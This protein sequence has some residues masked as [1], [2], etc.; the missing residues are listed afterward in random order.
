MAS[1]KL[2]LWIHDERFSPLDLIVQPENLSGYAVGDILEIRPS[3][4]VNDAVPT[5]KRLVMKVTGFDADICSKQTQLQI[6]INQHIAAI[7]ELQPRKDVVVS[8]IDPALIAADCI[9]L[10]FKDQYIGRGDMFRLKNSLTESCIYVGKKVLF[11]GCIRAQVKEIYA[12]GSQVFSAYVT[13][14]TKVIFRSE[15]AKYFIFLQ[16]S[17]DMF[18]MDSSGN[19]LLDRAIHGFFPELFERW[20]SLNSNHVVSIILSAR[21]FYDMK[22]LEQCE[23]LRG[24]DYYQQSGKHH[25]DY[26][27]VVS[28]WETRSDWTTILS[29]L[30]GEV[31]KF[32]DRIMMQKVKRMDVVMG[33]L[34]SSHESNV[35][36]AVN[37]ALN[38][39]DKHY[40]D[41]DL[42]RTGLSITM[43]TGGSGS[44]TVDKNLLRLT[45]ERMIEDGI[46]LDWVCLNKPPLF[47][48]PLFRFEGFTQ[49]MNAT[50]D[51]LYDDDVKDGP[52]EV[53]CN[54]PH[55]VDMSFYFDY[56][57]FRF[58]H[59]SRLAPRVQFGGARSKRFKAIIPPLT[60]NVSG[61]DI[62]DN[63]SNPANQAKHVGLISQQFNL[64]NI[65]Q[66]HDGFADNMSPTGGRIAA[67]PD[68]STTSKITLPA[69]SNSSH[70]I[71]IL[72]VQKK[73]ERHELPGTSFS[74]SFGSMQAS[75]M[76]QIAKEDR[77]NNPTTFPSN[78]AYNVVRISNHLRRWHHVFPRLSHKKFDFVKWNSLCTPACLPLTTDYFPTL[79]E[80]QD[81]YQEYTY[82]ISLNYEDSSASSSEN[83]FME[84]IAQRLIQGF[85]LVVDNAHVLEHVYLSMGQQIHKLVY[86]RNAQNVD[87]KRYVKR[88]QYATDEITY[89]CEISTKDSYE[90]S[91][92]YVAFLYPS[93]GSYN[94]NYLDHV[95]SGYQEELT[96]SLRFWRTRFILIPMETV[97]SN[98]FLN[99]SNESL[100]EEEIRLAGF[101]KFIEVF[102]RGGK[103]VPVV[104]TTLNTSTYVM[105]ELNVWQSPADVPVESVKSDLV[106][107]LSKDSKLAAITN[108]LQQGIT[109]K[110]RRWHLKYY[111]NAFVGSEC[112][113]WLVR[114]F[115]DIKTRE[116]AVDFGRTLL[117]KGIF[118]HVNSKHNFLDGHYFYRVSTK[119]PSSQAQISSPLRWFKK[120]QQQQITNQSSNAKKVELSRKILIDLDPQKKSYRIE[121]AVLHFD[122]VHNPNNCFHFHLHWLMCTSRLLDDMLQSWSRFAEKCGLK[123]VEAPV[124]SQD[125]PF[126]APIEIYPCVLPPKVNADWIPGSFK[127]PEL[128]FEIALLKK[129]GFVLDVE[130]DDR[131]P[132]DHIAYS[133][134]RTAYKYSQYV[135]R[136]G[137][138]FVQIRESGNGFLWVNNRL[139]LLRSSV[140]QLPEQ[141]R[142][143]FSCKMQDRAWLQNFWSE[144]EAQLS[145]GALLEEFTDDQI[146]FD[147]KNT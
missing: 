131:F 139:Q 94:W 59:I 130:A 21:I 54:F 102:N 146:A 41:R 89:K 9:E 4:T 103:L 109:I 81:S 119:D 40:I 144:T 46:G 42:L 30:K 121:T 13:K 80:L 114:S 38:V 147:Q 1:R 11:A 12:S 95:V 2:N 66:F 115:S 101:L 108:A 19:L 118:E 3:H 63:E 88:V 112:V 82:T 87:V 116:E 27:K 141:L 75:T 92:R 72:K 125:N 8:R 98:N 57:H 20:K 31:F 117:S 76:K 65:H 107:K 68:E 62:Y 132:M 71:S 134:K 45:T 29:Y 83:L 37:L 36:E 58:P 74:K 138:A 39:F 140:I 90:F 99:P 145:T 60:L 111:E 127:V 6:S 142:S 86:D 78:P 52:R 25:K 23:S 100:S 18:F 15:S 73:Q 104:L 67:L 26:Y 84:L 97:T 17:Q 105:N 110:D 69:D 5:S 113:D 120:S 64:D 61:F 22:D 128:L 50:F 135:H 55:W 35:L 44:L 32:H 49:A 106:E 129:F 136:S 137:T 33:T 143:E 28:D 43:I 10:A 51:P 47:I 85:Q 70:P 124:E 91:I 126:Q 53:Y 93:I 7:F 24:C 16:L 79:Q 123:L 56:K 77:N 133:F 34:A 122:A 96:E 48:V 14:H